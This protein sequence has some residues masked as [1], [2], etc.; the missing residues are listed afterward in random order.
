M[1]R[2]K[3]GAH[4]K[5]KAQHMHSTR[6]FALL[7][8]CFVLFMG[9]KKDSDLPDPP[10]GD[11]PVPTAIKYLALGDSYT[12]GESV[13]ESERWPVLLREKLVAN[14][15][16]CDSAEII[17]RTGWR[18]DNLSNAI[19]AADLQPE[20]DLVSLLIGVNNQYQGRSL[21]EYE[22]Q[23]EEL[24]NTA[25]T[26]A[27]GDTAKVFVV[28]IPDY[29]Y[30]PFG[31]S[32]QAAISPAIDDFNQAHLDICLQYGVRHFNITPISREGL[33]QPSYVAPDGLHP[34]GEQ[35]AAWVD[36]IYPGVREMA[37]P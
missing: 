28:S 25:I 1:F 10:T 23:F 7:A 35:Y 9:C 15:I 22:T 2:P 13:P 11:E 12:I 16:D 33:N 26:L 20:Y 36:L 18:T 5:S 24:L 21:S 8:I 27:G 30:T 17:A 19:E 3:S 31:A 32:N 14:D 6:T 29:G 37:R 4:P 34:S